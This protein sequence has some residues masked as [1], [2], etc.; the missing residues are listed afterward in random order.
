MDQM[1]GM[2]RAVTEFAGLRAIWTHR[3]APGGVVQRL[4]VRSPSG[5]MKT[6][7][8]F[9]R[10]STAPRI[11]NAARTSTMF[12]AHG[13]ATRA[14]RCPPLQGRLARTV[15]RQAERTVRLGCHGVI[16]PGVSPAEVEPIVREYRKR[17]PAERFE[18]LKA[19]PAG[20]R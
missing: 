8:A 1:K 3:A 13:R 12:T 17:R 6:T 14:S 20:S 18:R 7:R 15:R 2:T 16:L 5:L 4:R 10:A 11:C 9:A 19:N